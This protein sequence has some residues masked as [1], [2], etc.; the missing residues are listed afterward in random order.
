MVQNKV[1]ETKS[2]WYHVKEKVKSFMLVEE[3][4]QETPCL[5]RQA[6]N[7][8]DIVMSKILSTTLLQAILALSGSHSKKIS[9]LDAGRQ[10]KR[11]NGEES[12][13]QDCF[14]HIKE[15]EM[16][17][18]G[19]EKIFELGGPI[20]YKFMNLARTDEEKVILIGNFLGG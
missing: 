8:L 11:T 18:R 15:P 13:K 16:F 17:F 3:N 19:Q 9:E 2:K 5:F 20:Y 7:V 4:S 14:E 12:W 10:D 6:V 1:D